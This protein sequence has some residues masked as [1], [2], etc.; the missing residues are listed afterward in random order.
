M[1]I[2]D[3]AMTIEQQ[4]EA[5]YRSF[6]NDLSDKGAIYIFSWLADQEKR[7]Y[8]IFQKIKQGEAAPIGKS[9]DLQGVR[10]VFLDWKD[11]ISRLGVQFPQIELYRQALDVE[12]KSVRLYEEGARTVADEATRTA[13]LN[14]A[15]E[16][17]AH[18]QIMKNIIEFVIKPEYWTENAE[19]GYRGEDYYL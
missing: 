8:D 4:G 6:A 10:D 1:D 18:R 5:L 11:S 15:I 13:F 14:I 16:E 2:I 9:S 17:K 19:F 3:Q 7:H 12:E